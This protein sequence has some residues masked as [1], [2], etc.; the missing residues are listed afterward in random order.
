MVFTLYVLSEPIPW[1]T[2]H[3]TL[4]E[5]Q[6]SLKGPAMLITLE[7]HPIVVEPKAAAAHFGGRA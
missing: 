7:D 5:R 2:V 6:F 4:V 3:S 1:G